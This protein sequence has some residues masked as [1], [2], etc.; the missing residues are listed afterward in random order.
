MPLM[1]LIEGKV[2]TIRQGAGRDPLP[3]RV[4]LTITLI[5]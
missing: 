1:P 3:Y 4:A 2:T 5:A